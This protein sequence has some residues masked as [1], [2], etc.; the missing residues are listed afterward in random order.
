[1]KKQ[2]AYIFIAI[3]LVLMMIAGVIAWLTG[4]IGGGDERPEPTAAPTP[5]IETPA[6]EKTPAPTPTAV[7]TATPEPTATPAPTPEQPSGEVVDSGA[8]DSNTGVG[9]NTHTVWTVTR[10]ADGSCELSLSVYARSYSMGI[11]QRSIA[12]TV[13]GAVKT[14]T[15][16]A[17]EVDSPN[18]QTETLIYTCSVPVSEGSVSVSVDWS[19]KGQYS[20]QELELI[21]SQTS[22]T[23]K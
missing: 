11:G 5:D 21:S 13:N 2:T 18:A 8:F 15:T 7:P 17:F 4:G 1:M 23:V 6:P 19:Y 14:A 22:L 9:L 3:V 20:G 16:R 12:V 10:A